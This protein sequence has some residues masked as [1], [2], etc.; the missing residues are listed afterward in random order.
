MAR[1]AHACVQVAAALA[2]AMTAPAAAG[3]AAV[4]ARSGP[5]QATLTGEEQLSAIYN[6]GIARVDHGWIL[7]GTQV[8]ARV[9][10][11]LHE[12]AQVLRPIPDGLTAQGFNHV[13]DADVYGKYIYAPLEQPNYDL[14]QQAMARYDAKTLAFVDSV[15][16]PQ[17]EASFVTVD[18]KTKIAYTMDRF[19]GDA[20]LRYRLGKHNAWKPL[21]PLKL[22]RTIQRVQGA[23]VAN[24]AIW[25]STDDEGNGLY[26][27][28]IKSGHVDPVGTAG[29]VD[30]EGEGIDAT[31]LPSGL[32]HVLTVDVKINPVYLG[33]LK[34]SRAR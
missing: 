18:A 15:M 27:V 6:Q 30:G 8:I 34:V 5:P 7:T 2:L 14:G 23:D 12:L 3:A 24:G 25:L 19:D 20:L 22:D 1:L 31:K 4:S 21:R 9:D 28:D 16:V 32:L 26:R 13:G 17:H 10:D 33:H 11:Q 29:H